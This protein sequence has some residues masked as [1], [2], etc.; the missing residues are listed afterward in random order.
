M[1][2]CNDMWVKRFN[3]TLEVVYN[4]S[5]SHWIGY[6]VTLMHGFKNIF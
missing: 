3:V 6:N 5:H 2:T 1:V 4:L